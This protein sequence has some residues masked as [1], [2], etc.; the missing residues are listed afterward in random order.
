MEN[1]LVVTD[2]G[3][4]LRLKKR[5]QKTILRKREVLA[6]TTRKAEELKMD[7][8]FVKYEYDVRIGRLTLRDNQLDLEIIRSKNIKRLLEEGK[9][10][11]QAVAEVEDTYYSE[12]LAFEKEQEKIAYEAQ[13]LEKREEVDNG[14][15]SDMRGLWK[16]L[17]V[18]YHP[19]LVMD[20]QERAKREV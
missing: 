17:I 16:K 20:V 14:T 9:T 6:S 1:R 4:D 5:L 11:E 2:I 13:L 7:L 10:Y 18:R 12:Q 8:D 15:F 3:D 19:D